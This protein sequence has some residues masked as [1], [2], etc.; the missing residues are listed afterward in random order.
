MV[1]VDNGQCGNRTPNFMVDTQF[2]TVGSPVPQGTCFGDSG[3]SLVIDQNSENVIV[4][5]CS[6]TKRVNNTCLNSYDYPSYFTRVHAYLPWI[7]ER[8]SS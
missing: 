7:N 8:I 1:I 4:G 6:Y 5:I 2:C 3:G